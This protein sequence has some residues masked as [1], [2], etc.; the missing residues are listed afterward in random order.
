MCGS[1]FTLANTGEKQYICLRSKSCR[2]Q[3][4]AVSLKGGNFGALYLVI[5][6]P[7]NYYDGIFSTEISPEEHAANLVVAR[8]SN[9]EAL[10][11]S[12]QRPPGQSG[13]QVAFNSPMTQII[14]GRPT[15]ALAFANTPSTATTSDEVFEMSPS[16]A[17][18]E[19]IR[20]A[21]ELLHRHEQEQEMARVLA[22]QA[23]REFNLARQ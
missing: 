3:D 14:D 12:G 15:P 2:C 1:I 11:V 7:N 9:Q 8:E 18:P 10:R 17:E 16:Q 21:R 20:L 22:L 23:Q 5:K 13:L 6:N 4:H 19:H